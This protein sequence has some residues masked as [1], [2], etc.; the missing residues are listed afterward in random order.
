VVKVERAIET[1]NKDF[2]KRSPAALLK[3][4][5]PRELET[6]ARGLAALHVPARFDWWAKFGLTATPAPTTGVNRASDRRRCFNC[7]RSVSDSVIA[8]CQS[9]PGQF[10]DKVYCVDCQIPMVTGRA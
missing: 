10:A 6:F 7:G 3:I 8:F 5:T 1:I 2:D 9:R 4:V